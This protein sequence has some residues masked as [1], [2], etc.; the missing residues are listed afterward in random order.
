MIVMQGKILRSKFTETKLWNKYPVKV[1]PIRDIFISVP[2]TETLRGKPFY[3]LLLEDIER[4][5]LHFPLLV[6]DPTRTDL[7]QRKKQYK[8]RMC[9]LPEWNDGLDE[10]EI[11][12]LTVWGGSQRIRVAADLGYTHIDCA[13]IPTLDE[14]RTLQGKMR[15]PFTQR[16]Y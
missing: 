13:I 4:D 9:D 5:G 2:K 8:K 11:R 10:N 3:K 12:H 6:S 7:R 14:A 16:Y 15:A 1:L